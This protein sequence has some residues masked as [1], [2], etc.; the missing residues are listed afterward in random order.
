MLNVRIRPCV[1]SE[2]K[3]EKEENASGDECVGS[4]GKLFENL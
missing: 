2:G 1:F 4:D 3:A